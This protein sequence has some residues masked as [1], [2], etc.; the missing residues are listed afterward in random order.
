MSLVVPARKIDSVRFI[1]K[2]DDAI[3][4]EQSDR[5]AYEQDP[6]KNQDK[7]VLLPGKEPTV[8]VLNLKLSAQQIKEI[9]DNSVR[10]VDKD[11]GTIITLGSWSH[12]VCKVILKDIINPK[13]VVNPLVKYKKDSRGYVAEDVMDVLANYGI[14]DEIFACYNKMTA[15]DEEVIRQGKN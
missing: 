6:V 3:D 13:D 4:I 7:L 8:F 12:M 14:L 2:L 10:G 15:K 9:K 11:S 1:S 5:E